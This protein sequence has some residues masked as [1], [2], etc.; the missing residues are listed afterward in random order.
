M[1]TTIYKTAD[2]Q[3]VPSVTTYLGIL[4][5]PALVTWAWNLGIQGVDFRKVRDQAADTGTIVHDLATSQLLGEEPDLTKYSPIELATTEIPMAKFEEWIVD[6]DIEPLAVEHPFVSET[7][8]YGG[9]PDF[10]GVVNGVATLLDIKTSKDIYPEN[11]YQLA[12]YKQLLEENGF[13][14]ETAKVL[15]IGKSA[16]EGFE[17]MGAGN[18]DKHFEI[19]LACQTIYEL[20]KDIKRRR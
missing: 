19:F 10:F 14:V 17:E 2:G 6:K 13:N 3:R 15:R 16:D 9:T 4:N 1:P 8:R 18:L 11:F 7:Y 12:A 20:Q 5:K